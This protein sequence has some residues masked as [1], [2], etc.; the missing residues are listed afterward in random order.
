MMCG[1]IFRR[2]L[3]AFLIVICLFSVTI[4]GAKIQMYTATAED[5]ANEI[6]SQDIAKLRAR[7]KAIKKATKQ[8]GVYLKSYSRSVNNELTDD[9]ITAITSNA[10]QL[11]GEP[12]YSRTV[13]QVS[14]ETTIIVWKATVEINVDDSEIQSWIKREDNDKSTIISQT[15]EAQKASEENE[16]QIEDLREKYNRAT[17]QA[18]KDNLRKQ[19]TNAD[20]DFLAN[21]KREE[22]N[23]LKYERDYDGAIKLYKEAINNFTEIIMLNPDNYL[24]YYNRGLS[25]EYIGEC[26]TWKALEENKNLIIH[27]YYIGDTVFITAISFESLEQSK[28]AIKDF[29]KAIQLKSNYSEA[30]N[31]RGECYSELNEQLKAKSDFDKVIQLNPNYVAY[32]NRA[33]CYLALGDKQKAQ[34]DF[35]KSIEL[36]PNYANNYKKS[37]LAYIT[38]G[39]YERAIQDFDKA[40]QFYPNDAEAYAGRGS[41]YQELGDETKAQADFVKAKQLGYKG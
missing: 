32:K 6:E 35:V 22:G 31:S 13:K 26:Y 4:V 10:W 15:R 29:D 34:I 7:D 38:I 25:N 39:Q 14:D 28:M 5:Y 8:A 9:E 3:T 16:R 37:G 36:N 40:I 18:E 11:V 21:Q 24:A 12:K 27:D 1:K 41:C 17:S 19:M 33:E 30:Y 2:G 20:R 23:K